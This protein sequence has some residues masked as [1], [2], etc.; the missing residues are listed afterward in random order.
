MAV[1]QHRE[2]PRSSKSSRQQTLPSG[3]SFAGRASTNEPCAETCGFPVSAP[4]ET[5]LGPPQGE[6]STRNNMPRP[7][8]RSALQDAA[9]GGSSGQGAHLEGRG[10]ASTRVLHQI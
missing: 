5:A 8:E 6:V 9:C 10:T 4:F 3:N 7:E 1:T 2:P